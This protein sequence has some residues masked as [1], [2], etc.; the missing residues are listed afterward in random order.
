[1]WT[2]IVS[3][4]S[5]GTAKYVPLINY[6]IIHNKSFVKTS[7]NNYKMINIKH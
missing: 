2:L 3:A 4:P 5:F 6:A 1:M 7:T